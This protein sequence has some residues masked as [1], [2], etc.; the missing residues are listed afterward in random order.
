M[1]SPRRGIDAIK[2]RSL[3]QRAADLAEKVRA[4]RVICSR[5][6]VDDSFPAHACDDGWRLLKE[7]KR[8]QNFLSVYMGTSPEG[9]T[10]DQGTLW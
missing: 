4:H 5:C 1:T 2:T 9:T 8:A 10:N 6:K 7:H 3:K